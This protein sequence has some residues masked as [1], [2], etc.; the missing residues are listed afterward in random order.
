MT[1]NSKAHAQKGGEK[2]SKQKRTKKKTLTPA[3]QMGEEC[4]WLYALTSVVKGSVNQ[5]VE[6]GGGGR[7]AQ[8]LV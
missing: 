6:K 8:R 4:H 7:T 5:A 1:T 2:A 3:I